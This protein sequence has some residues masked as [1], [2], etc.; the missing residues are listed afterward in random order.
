MHAPT[1]KALLLAGNTLACWGSLVRMHTDREQATTGVSAGDVANV[2]CLHQSV[3]V[4]HQV[5]IMKLGVPPTP[6]QNRVQVGYRS[7]LI[8]SRPADPPDLAN[9]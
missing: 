1:A 3:P 6:E 5:L 2:A 4:E 9:R 7:R 8:L